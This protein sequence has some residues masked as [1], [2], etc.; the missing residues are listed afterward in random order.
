MELELDRSY[1]DMW[2][3][4]W[5]LLIQVPWGATYGLGPFCVLIYVLP[6]VFLLPGDL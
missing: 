6:C 3:A 5:M 4:M 1:L 2:A